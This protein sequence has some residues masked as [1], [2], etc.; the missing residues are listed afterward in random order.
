[1]RFMTVVLMAGLLF[2][3]DASAQ[4]MR[5]RQAGGQTFMAGQGQGPRGERTCDGTGPKGQGG[6]K[7]QCQRSGQMG[8]C[9]R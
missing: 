4:R 6:G 5:G 7:G 8:R 9:R 1:M 3:V 2:T